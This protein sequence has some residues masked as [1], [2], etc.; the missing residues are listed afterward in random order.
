[1]PRKQSKIVSGKK[2][3]EEDVEKSFVEVEAGNSIRKT[4]A[5]YGMS[6]GILRYHLEMKKEGKSLTGSGKT[7]AI[8]QDTEQQLAICIGTMCNLGFSPTRAQIK[9][10]CS[11]VCSQ[12]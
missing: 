7:T 6:E 11:R 3:S 1:M 9:R 5:K 8:G 4:A 10:S 12:P 2:W